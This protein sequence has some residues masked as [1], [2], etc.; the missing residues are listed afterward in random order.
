MIGEGTGGVADVELVRP[1]VLA[2]LGDD[3]QVFVEATSK[4]ADR[5]AQR[6]LERLVVAGLQGFLE[7]FAMG[8][9]GRQRPTRREGGEK[10]NDS[11]LTSDSHKP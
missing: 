11:I 8:N 6:P 4:M 10:R 7:N 9:C 2:D 1:S 3:C 5:T